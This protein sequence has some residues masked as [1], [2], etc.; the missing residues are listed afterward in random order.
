MVGFLE[1]K[2]KMKIVKEGN[3]IRL[4]PAHIYDEDV[5]QN[6]F[7]KKPEKK[8]YTESDFIENR[9]RAREALKIINS[10]FPG[11]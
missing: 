9:K 11:V 7:S 8:R 5:G 4:E 2:K 3:T 1:G 6:L 10:L